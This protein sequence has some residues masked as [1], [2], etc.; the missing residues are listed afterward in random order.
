[1]HKFTNFSIPSSPK[2]SLCTFNSLLIHPTFTSEWA[3]KITTDLPALFPLPIYHHHHHQ[4]ETQSRQ[5]F[6]KEPEDTLA[7]LGQPVDLP[8]LIENKRGAVSWRRGG[9]FLGIDEIFSS[10]SSRYSMPDQRR[11]APFQTNSSQQLSSNSTAYN[12]TSLH[13]TD[14]FLNDEQ[15]NSDRT[16]TATTTITNS[17][18]Y[19]KSVSLVEDDYFQ[20][21]VAASDGPYLAIKSN[22]IKLTV[23]EPP[24]KLSIGILD[25]E[26]AASAFASSQVSMSNIVGARARANSQAVSHWATQIITSPLTIYPLIYKLSTNNFY[27]Q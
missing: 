10:F 24:S 9:L 14:L 18:L 11:Q 25:E 21:S 4:I 7:L 20:C 17:S 6:A 16:T 1:M 22:S 5:R 23:L 26:Q 3:N 27:A 12:Q 13:S 8:C 15:T 19:I 2:L